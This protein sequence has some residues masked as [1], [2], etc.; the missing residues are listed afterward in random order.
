MSTEN[1]SSFFIFFL[2]GLPLNLTIAILDDPLGNTKSRKPSTELKKIYKVLC[3]ISSDGNNENRF[4]F[5]C[6]HILVLLIA[7]CVRLTFPNAFARQHH[8]VWILPVRCTLVA[9]GWRT[10]RYYTATVLPLSPQSNG[11][12]TNTHDVKLLWASA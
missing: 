10:F 5:G 7:P 6:T 12:N 9:A 1:I 4:A 3:S 11:K 2:I 8:L